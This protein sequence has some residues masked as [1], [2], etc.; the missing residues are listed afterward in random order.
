MLGWLCGTATLFAAESPA[1]SRWL[2]AAAIT[3]AT[4]PEQV[5]F[6]R[7]VAPVLTKAGCNS[8]ACHGSFQGR[9]G[10]QLSLLGY[11]P[12][13]DYDALMKAGRGRRVNP[14]APEASLLLRKALG[15]MPH[16]GGSRWEAGSPAQQIVLRYLQQGLQPPS[17]AEPTLRRLQVTHTSVQLA[18]GSHHA[19]RASAEWSDGV[20]RDVTGWCLFD[21]RERLIAEV[22]PDGVITA[23]GPGL[24]AVTVRFAGHVAA[25]TVEVPLGQSAEIADFTPVNFIDEEASR[26]WRRLGVTPAPRASDA[27]FLRRVY[28]DVIGTLP[29]PAEIRSFLQSTAPDKRSQIIGALLQRPEY[30]D[31]WSLRWGDLLRVHRRYVGDKGLASFSG[32]LRQSIRENKPIDVLTRELL[33]AQGNVF[34]SGPVAYYFTDEKPEDL[35]ETTAQV[36]LGVRLQCARC[37]HHPN[38][39]WSQ[40][41]YYGLAAFFTRLEK[42]DTGDE[43]RFGGFRSI[44]PVPRDVPARALATPAAPSLLGAAPDLAATPDWRTALAAWITSRD[45]PYFAR[46]FANRYWGWLIGRGLVEPVDDLRATNPPSHPELLDRLAREFIE[47]G[48]DGR[49]LVRLI[50]ESATYQ[51]ASE[52]TPTRDGDGRLLTHRVPRRLPAEVLLDAVNQACGTREAFAGQPTG[53]RAIALPDPTIASTFLNTFGRP[54]RNSPCECARGGLPDLSQTLHLLNSAALH[55]KVSGAES[56]PALLLREK[57]TDAERLEELY[58]ATLSR[59]PTAEEAATVQTLLADSP[60]PAEGWQDLLWALLNSAEFTFQH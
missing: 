3:D 30:V 18:P 10:L 53:T 58:L 1:R 19:L 49:H 2:T 29:T 13:V 25:V 28:L 36:F 41:D 6:A 33:T 9:G 47:H 20:V 48:Y 5:S 4:L 44:R 16:G 55:D 46:S 23:Q 39:T 60:T 17:G 43:G 56:R 8:G 50:C 22:S 24:T 37:H 7:D 57:A 27:E 51:R 34:T 15:Q 45:N 21:A 59:L 35:A 32:W 54:L 42:K 11:D 26:A 31:H 52:L 38:E 14:S 40:Q 12:V